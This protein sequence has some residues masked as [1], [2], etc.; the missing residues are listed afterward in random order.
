[1]DIEPEDLILRLQSG[2]VYRPG[3]ARR[4]LD[5]FF[6]KENLEALREIA[7]RRTADRLSRTAQKKGNESGVRAGEHILVCLSSAPSSARVI[8]TAARMAEAFHSGFTALYVEGEQIREMKGDELKRLRDNIRLAE[9]MG[10]QIATVY[11]DEP[12]VQIAEYA[13][14]SGVTKIVIG[15]PNQRYS[16]FFHSKT[17][18]DQLTDLVGNMDLYIIPDTEASPYRRRIFFPRSEGPV[19]LW[20][21]LVKMLTVVALSTLVAYGFFVAGLRDANIITV[22]IL[23]VL[24]TAIW[25]HGHLYGIF[26]SFLSVVVFNYFFTVPQFTL[27]VIDPDYPITFLIML[28]ASLIS[29]TLAIRVKKQAQQASQKAYYTELLMNSSQKLQ[30]G[31]TEEEIIALAAEQLS[32][33]LDRPILYALNKG[34]EELA[35]EAVPEEQAGRLL[36][37]VTAEER[38]VADWVVKNKK[39]AGATTN[40]LSNAQNLYLAVRGMQGVMGV[41]GIPSRYY[42]EPE[43]FEKNLMIA[44]VNE[45]GLILERKRMA[46]EKVNVEMEARQ[47]RLRANL[48]RAIS[49]D[50]RTPLTSISGNAGVLMEK[51]IS[52]GEEKKQELYRSIYDDSMWLVNLTENLL[53]ITRIENGTMHLQRNTE[54]VEDVFEEALQHLDRQ[55]K[56]HE[57]SVELPDDLLMAEMDVR[58]IV[59]VIINI[60]NNAVKYTPPGSHIVLRAEKKEQMAVI[61]ISD[62]GPGIPDE[63]KAHLFDMFYTVGKGKSDNRRGLGLGLNLCRSIVMAHGGQISVEDNRPHG[64]VFTFTLPLKEVE[65]QDV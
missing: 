12:A 28:T 46:E 37:S 17:L 2:K 10:A 22:Y 44:I 41:V 5:H 20:Q 23:G 55:A 27:E 31:K 9:Q 6:T 26:G 58:L 25:T 36:A 51:D 48:L 11:G 62:D 13:R 60:V 33:L 56:E 16:R 4:A 63:G 57:I 19:F 50:L 8:R 32:A 24:I 3:Q 18:A 29:S 30:Q 52:L 47:E 35:F 45:C 15:R 64:S 38:G 54:L 21:D 7:L 43:V 65:V 39:R 42:P 49:H 40:T 34:E 1:M 14:V 59:Q 61:R 53:S